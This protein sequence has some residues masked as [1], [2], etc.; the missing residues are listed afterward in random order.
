MLIGGMEDK[1][2]LFPRLGQALQVRVWD[3]RKAG[4][5]RKSGAMLSRGQNS[6]GG[7]VHLTHAAGNDGWVIVAWPAAEAHLCFLSQ[8]PELSLLAPSPTGPSCPLAPG[9]H[10]PSC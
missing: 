2:S 4:G 9:Q 3:R 6:A 5:L 8:I 7:P 10:I 1:V